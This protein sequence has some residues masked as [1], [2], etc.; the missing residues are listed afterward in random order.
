MIFVFFSTNCASY[1]WYF[2]DNVFVKFSQRFVFWQT[3]SLRNEALLPFLCILFT[4]SQS[5]L[6][7]TSFWYVSS[8]SGA[9]QWNVQFGLLT[10]K[11]AL[12]KYFLL[13]I[14][15]VLMSI[16]GNL[17]WYEPNNP[18]KQSNWQI[19]KSCL[20][21]MERTN[22]VESVAAFVFL[23]MYVH[24]FVFVPFVW[25]KV[26]LANQIQFYLMTT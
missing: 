1:F 20:S 10:T 7:K 18:T 9:S 25:N 16:H 22:W 12:Y 26:P 19:L 13:K 2:K 8:M 24:V 23:Y 6:I 15:T 17:G 14:V 3:Q 11:Y 21:E 5:K 4:G